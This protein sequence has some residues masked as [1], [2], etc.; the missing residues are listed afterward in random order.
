MLRV[1]FVTLFPEMTLSACRHSI[2][3]RAEKAGIV[4]FYATNP[5]DL[6]YDRHGKVD[7]KPFGGS[8]GMLIGV[9]PTAMTLQ[10]L[11]IGNAEQSR[12]ERTAVVITDPTGESFNQS[13]ANEFAT[14]DRVVFLCGH[15][16]GFDD[17]VRE[18]FA[19]HA[20]GIGDYI[21]TGGELPALVMTDAIVRRLEGVLGSADSLA[22]DSHSDG[23]LSAPQYTRPEE[24]EGMAVPEVLLSGDHKKIALW[25]REQ[26]LKITASR[27]P[28]LLMKANLD[29]RDL[30]MLSS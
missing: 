23:L 10:S 13:L 5:R 1:D 6:T 14:L 4:S 29:K 28:D 7:D 8:P 24:F 30:D 3:H 17:R 12:Q 18:R 21:L 19:T 9:E 11:G 26:A 16:E 25:Q 22:A 2:L 15:Y 27:R 20:I